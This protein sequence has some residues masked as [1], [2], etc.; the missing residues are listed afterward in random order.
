[1]A[2]EQE[3]A[4]AR[5]ALR[6]EAANLAA[7]IADR[8]VKEKIGDNDQERLLDEFITRVDSTPAAKA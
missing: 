5:R 3:F 4:R 2:A 6:A 8:L 1:M 7:E